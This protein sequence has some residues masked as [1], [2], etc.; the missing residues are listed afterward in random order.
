MMN[1]P[2]YSL[3]SRHSARA[4]GQVFLVPKRAVDAD[5]DRVRTSGRGIAC[6]HPAF[7]YLFRRR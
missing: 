7:A 6:T 5:A 1:R 4:K 2:W 3:P